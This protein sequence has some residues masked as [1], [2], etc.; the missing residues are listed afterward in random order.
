MIDLKFSGIGAQMRR[1]G[2]IVPSPTLI[3]ATLLGVTTALGWHLAP[4][5]ALVTVEREPLVLFPDRLG[6]WRGQSGRIESKVEQVLGADDYSI[7]KYTSPDE[8]Q[9]VEFFIAWYAKQTEGEGIHSPQVC[10]PAGG[11]EVSE[12]ATTMVTLATGETVPLVRAVI[13]KGLARQLVYYWFEL[14]GRRLTNDYVAKAYTVWDSA[15]L[16]RTDGAIVRLITPIGTRDGEAA[17]EA[18]LAR[19]MAES[20]P[21]IPRFVPN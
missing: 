4:T 20:L 11:W 15:V 3:A 19:F 13:Q 7:A 6:D 14:R 17:G 12:W 2:T 18:R 10:I 16:G 8:A 5:P 1:A 21:L 9:P